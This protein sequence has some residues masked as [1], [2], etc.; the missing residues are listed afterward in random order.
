MTVYRPPYYF[1]S[2]RNRKSD[3]LLRST[4]NAPTH[5]RN[6]HTHTTHTQHHAQRTTYVTSPT[7]TLESSSIRA[8]PSN[9]YT[10]IGLSGPFIFNLTIS[11]FLITILIKYTKYFD[12][13][14]SIIHKLEFFIIFIKS[15]S[16]K[17]NF[18]L[19][20]TSYKKIFQYHNISIFF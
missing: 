11:V 14:N 12:F 19:Y 15:S 10:H 20:Y 6:I 3:P 18:S 7:L 8:S 4:Q 5:A 16:Y 17:F 2:R 13:P 1:H 9:K